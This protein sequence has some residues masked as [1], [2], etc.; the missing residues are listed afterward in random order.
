MIYTSA[1]PSLKS[2]LISLDSRQIY[3]TPNT[4]FFAVR[5]I[6]HDGH[7]YIENLYKSG[8]KEFIVEKIAWTSIL[9]EKAKKWE[10]AD[11]YVVENSIQTLQKL[12]AQHRSKFDYN[13]VAITG[14]NGKTICKEWLATLLNGTYNLVKSPKSFNSQIGVPLSVWAMKPNHNLGIFEAGI[15]QPGEMEKLE[16]ILKP[17]HG[18]LTHF[19][20]AHGANF[21]QEE[22]KLQ[23]KL[24]LFK[25]SKTLIYRSNNWNKIIH[26][27][28]KSINPEI[29]LIEWS[30]EDPTKNIFVHF[31]RSAHETQI[32]LKKASQ[33]E[34]F[35]DIKT[36]LTDDASL[37]NICHCLIMAHVL[38]MDNL[39]IN[40]A[41]R[42][43]KPISMRLEIKEGLRDI[44]IIDDSYNNDIDGLRLALPLL[45]KYETKKKILIIS[46][47]LEIGLPEENLYAEINTMILNQKIDLIIGI[48]S[49]ISRNKNK[50][51]GIEVYQSTEDFLKSGKLNFDFNYV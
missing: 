44:K 9:L 26:T 22:H 43:V 33:S 8:I 14:S 12:A 42:R 37:E 10:D 46:D 51:N 39:A 36:E 15:S 47:F 50:I 41:I 28:I 25:N 29:E 30:T 20:E 31:I 38:G 19:G 5:G 45:M 16:A 27:Y 21:S 2:T 13:L 11:F 49:Q 1:P 24:M 48:G 40:L 3:D 23:E 32:K 35:I 4:A 6:H 34:P 18:I 7:Q 17:S